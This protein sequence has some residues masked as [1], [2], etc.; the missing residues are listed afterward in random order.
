MRNIHARRRFKIIISA[1]L[2]LSLTIF[3]ET[4]IEAVVPQIRTLA[5]AELG[6]S[7]GPNVEFNIGAVDGGILQPFVMSDIK[8]K[9]KNGKTVL[10]SMA[11]NSIRTNIRLWD[12]LL[13]AMKNADTI[14]SSYAVV[15]FASSDKTIK[16]CVKFQGDAGHFNVKGFL[17]LFGDI[18]IDVAGETAKGDFALDVRPPHGAIAAKGRIDESGCFDIQLK[19][20]H[21]KPYGLDIVCDA[22]IKTSPLSVL[23]SGGESLKGQFEIKNLIINYKPFLDT[24][25]SFT[26]SDN[27]LEITE[28]NAG[29]MLIMRGRAAL[30]PPHTLD[31]TLTMNNVNLSWL[32]TSLGGAEPKDI[33]T[34]TMNAK[35]NI[36]G[37]AQ[38]SRLTVRLDMKKGTIGT[39]DFDSLSVNMKGDLPFLKI[40]DSR[41]TRQSG[42]FS[43]AGEMDLRKIGKGSLFDGIKLASDERAINWDGWESVERPGVEEIR[44]KKKLG[45]DFNIDIKKF[46]NDQRIDESI[47]DNDEIGIEY[48]LNQNKTLKMVVGQEKDFVG[49]EHKDKF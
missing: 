18:R 12:V 27:E 38:K 24:K 20:N 28:F 40:E 21:F 1:A 22:S 39:L 46:V 31:L 30:R 41:I 11:I 44:M 23:S 16:G 17:M 29:D 26:L 7:L 45:E 10:P 48:K 25:G 13:R 5:Q 14:K 42:S 2:L 32:V 47:R 35:I 33:L 6:R 15:T 37:P 9:D 49:F 8:I 3:I 36:A 19:I 43:L 34:G 4:Q